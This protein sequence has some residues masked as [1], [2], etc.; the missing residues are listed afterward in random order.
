MSSDFKAIARTEIDE[1]KEEYRRRFPG[2]S[3]DDVTDEDLLREVLNSVGKQGR[4]GEHVR[5]VVSV[6]MLTEGWDANTVTHILGVRA[7]GTQLLCEQVV[8][9]GLR[10]RSYAVD[11]GTGCFTPEYADVYGVPFQFIPT[12]AP[13][14]DL[15]VTPSRRVR[16]EPE[17]VSAEITFP[18]V[19]GYRVE[20]PDEPLFVDLGAAEP[21]V[22]SKDSLPTYTLVSG[23]VGRSDVHEL[24]ELRGLREQAVAYEIA[25]VLVDRHLS[26]MDDPKPWYF[27]QAVGIVRDWMRTC[28][29]YHDDTFPGLLLLS[30]NTHHAAE[31]VWDAV[32]RQVDDREPHVLPMMRLYDPVG[33][34]AEVD[35]FT[36]RD[37]YPT[38]EMRCHVSY[39][40]LDGVSGD[41]WERTVAQAL[42]ALPG[43][44][45]YVK[46]DHRGFTIPYP[47]QGRTH[48]FVPD[49]LVRLAD[50]GDSVLRTLVVEVSGGRKDQS[51]RSAKAD[52]ARD[53]W[54]PAVSNDGRWGRWGFCEVDDPT[55][56]NI[57]ISAAADALR[58]GLG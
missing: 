54:L 48:Q 17:R 5:C 46:N 10:R 21:F 55:R 7:F 33:S 19:V 8:G 53:L 2:R 44:A 6:S 20:L 49:F 26:T 32:I 25:R 40:V 28:V 39:V 36:T 42:E 1:F 11:P 51:M 16:A 38:S 3:A 12:V 34:T 30:E 45:A 31:R 57:D 41:A 9:P 37:V 4:L 52:A 43:V 29:T 58:G 56:A 13:T 24:G 50:D 14:K 35:F 18:R 15:T 23:V 22:V 47:H 27:P